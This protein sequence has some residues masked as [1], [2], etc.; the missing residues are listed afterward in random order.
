MGE[1]TDDAVDTAAVSALLAAADD[2]TA[3][4]LDGTLEPAAR[5]LGHR[6]VMAMV[7]AAVVGVLHPGS[8]WHGDAAVVARA[9]EWLADLEALQAPS[10]LFSSGDNLASP[11]DSAFTITDVAAVTRLLRVRGYGDDPELRELHDRLTAVLEAAAGALVVG[12]VHTPNHRW[13]L[14]GALART[15]ALL[16]DDALLDRARTWLAEG[17]DVDDDGLYSERSPNYAAFVSNHS[18]TTLADV[19]DRPDLHEVVHRSLHTQLDL[20]DDR[21][22]VET[23]QSRR[24]DQNG[25]Y[26]LGPFAG[27]LRRAAV[28]HACARCGR[29]AGHAAEAPEL[30]A[31]DLLVQQLTEPDLAGPLPGTG[32]VLAADAAPDR[33]AP[34]AAAG[35]G[36]GLGGTAPD[37]PARRHLRDAR[38][39][40]DQRRGGARLTVYGGSDVPAIGRVASGLAC[41][42]TFLRARLGGTGV[43]SVRLSRDFF[44]LGPFRA[45][46]MDVDGDRVVLHEEV[47]AAYYQPLA[48]PALDPAGRYALEHE[49]R[50]AA[51]MSFS[52]RARDVVTL[53]TSVTVDLRDDG[54]DLTVTTDAPATG[55]ALEL[56][57]APGGELTGA[58]DRGDGRY[59]LVDGLARYVQGGQALVVGPGLGSG[60]DRPAL[61]RPGEVYTFLGGTDA[62]GGTRLYLTWRSPGTV[63]VSLRL[64]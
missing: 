2:E 48:G 17:V 18:L 59:E 21:G 41:N 11:P 55:H 4:L 47:S 12:G 44:G 51:A 45:S 39:L 37:A 9:R 38:L 30:D 57:L 23:V 8:R 13:E 42:P 28:R 19:L 6:G 53:T 40:V 25:P 56:A 32:A 33:L 36:P 3:G 10:G 22:N 54:A 60:P 46:T 34:P 27:Q 35:D 64:E 29:G 58:E 50:F 63:A 7:K 26:P 5:A 14:G 31:V 24:Q 1:R 20:T 61:Y 62:L 49:G 15:G 43:E 16:G 52:R